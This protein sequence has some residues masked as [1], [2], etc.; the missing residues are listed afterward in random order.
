MIFQYF[1]KLMT[2]NSSQ[3]SM[4]AILMYTVIILTIICVTITSI[5]KTV[6][7]KNKDKDDNIKTDN[8]IK[9]DSQELE[10]VNSNK[11][12]VISMEQNQPLPYYLSNSILTDYE[13]QLFSILFEYCTREK[14]F[15]FSKVRIADFI[16][17]NKNIKTYYQWFNRISS[18]H[19]DFLIC[20]TDT[21]KPILAIELDDYTHKQKTRQERDEFVNL[22]YSS[23]GLPILHITELNSDKICKDVSQILNINL[24]Q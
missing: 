17:I 19:V 7:N 20:K 1:V 14:L 13:K 23:V 12:S 21:F 2:I 9:K 3:T 18:K 16:Q 10:K 24:Y 22:V 5:I 4:D 15:L 11:T 8:E 6:M